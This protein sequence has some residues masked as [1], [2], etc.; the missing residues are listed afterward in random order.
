MR[1]EGSGWCLQ[2]ARERIGVE[3]K[4]SEKGTEVRSD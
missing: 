4:D 3:K 1:E 2:L